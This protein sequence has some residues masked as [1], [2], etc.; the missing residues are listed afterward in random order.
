MVIASAALLN[1]T[2]RALMSIKMM[3]VLKFLTSLNNECLNPLGLMAASDARKTVDRN[4]DQVYMQNMNHS[5]TKKHVY[6]GPRTP[7][8][9][10]I[11]E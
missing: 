9:F 10:T 7:V 1:N 3:I 4:L 5:M 2:G 6:L 8:P 11:L